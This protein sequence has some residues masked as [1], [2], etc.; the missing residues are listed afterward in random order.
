MAERRTFSRRGLLR[1]A[2]AAGAG[3]LVVAEPAQARSRERAVFVIVHGANGNA[4]ATAPLVTELA[5]A[6]HRALAVDLPGHGPAANFPVSYQAPQDSQAF[7]AAPS[8]V[9]AATSLQTNVD[10]VV[11][12]VRRAAD[13]GPVVLVGH[14]M[15]GAT[16]TRVANEVPELIDR[17]VYLTAFCCTALESVLDCFMTPEAATT[18]LPTIPSVGDPEQTG[19][20]R[21]NWRSAD[22]EFLATVKAALAGGYSDGGFMAALNLFEPDES[23]LVAA[24]DA[25]GDPDTWGRVARSYLRCTADRAIPLALQ[26]RMIA[27][28]D[29]ATPDN[30]FDVHDFDAPHLGP[31]DPRELADLLARLCRA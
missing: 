23:N 17:L 2:A 16:I 20:S 25:R 30:T 19:V 24:D 8:P 27:E 10:H 14:S 31:E 21:T 6:G 29:A 12:I 18:L 5:L 11:G 22:P 3:G 13:T 1:T 4:A 15:G 7:A 9:L 26:D 28:A